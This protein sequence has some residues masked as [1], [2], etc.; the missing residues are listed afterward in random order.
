MAGLLKTACSGPLMIDLQGT[1]LDAAERARLTHPLV[2]GLILFA[3]NYHSPAQLTAL[4]AEVRALRHAAGRAPLLIAVDQE[5]GR[6]QRF[7]SGFT[8]LPPMRQLGEQWDHDPEAAKAAAKT[9]GWTLASELRA[10]GVDLS[11]TPVLDLDYGRSGVIGDRAFH[12]RPKAVIDLAGALIAGLRQ[13]GMGCCGKHFPGHGWAFAD[14]HLALPTDE[15]S[16]AELQ[17]DLRPYR[18]LDLDAVMPAH[19]VYPA[20]DAEHTACFSQKWH[21]YLRH[22][23]GFTGLVFSDDLS[24]QAASIAGDALARARAAQA[25]GCDMLLLCNDPES[26]EYVLMMLGGKK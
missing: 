26:A 15:R 20:V 21:A 25:A 14:S 16:L 13:G 4:T 18:A 9:V 23:I 11:F 3:R 5:G 6:V 12:R 8:P 17:E 10:C 22:D 2:G 19:V 1:S 24:M 7:R